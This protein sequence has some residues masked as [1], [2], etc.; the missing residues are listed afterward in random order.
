ML[1]IILAIIAAILFGISTGIQKYSLE[2][3]SAFS[4]R[5]ILMNKKWL[6]SLLVGAVGILFYLVA[7]RVAELSVVQSVI[8]LTLI[9]QVLIGFIFFREKMVKIEWLAVI[10]VIAGVLLIAY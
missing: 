1:G 7:M 2:R 3:I 6:S 5:K 4:I 8:S 9:V 10:V